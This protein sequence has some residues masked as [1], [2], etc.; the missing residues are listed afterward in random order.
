VKKINLTN[1]FGIP[2]VVQISV[3]DSEISSWI[4]VEEN[5]LT[6]QPEESK[7]VTVYIN[8][9]QDSELGRYQGKMYVTYRTI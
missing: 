6:L 3:D 9:P 8:V 1:I 5:N 4:G 2:S 7:L